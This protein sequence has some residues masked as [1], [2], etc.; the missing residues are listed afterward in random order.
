M[1]L[2]FA[3]VMLESK[4]E[5]LYMLKTS[6]GVKACAWTNAAPESGAGVPHE[7]LCSVIY[8]R[9]IFRSVFCTVPAVAF[10]SIEAW[11]HGSLQALPPPSASCANRTEP[12]GARLGS[13]R[14]VE[15]T[16]PDELRCAL[17]LVAEQ[18]SDIDA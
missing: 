18:K 17:R 15:P 12:N 14:D 9:S 11:K 5:S 8:A 13:D 7:Q 6:S 4:L 10:E 2:R 3:L 16:P 1:G